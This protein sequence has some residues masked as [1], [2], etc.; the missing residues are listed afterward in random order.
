VVRE[1]RQ[2]L[3]EFGLDLDDDVEIQVHDSSSEVR[4]MVLPERPAGTEDYAEAGLADLVT[5]DAM[6]GVAQVTVP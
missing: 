1:P 3:R 4:Y 6:V 5:R 2:V